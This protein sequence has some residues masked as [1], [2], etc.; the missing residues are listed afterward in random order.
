[1]RA[2]SKSHLKGNYIETIIKESKTN[3]KGGGTNGKGKEESDYY[4]QKGPSSSYSRS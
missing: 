4:N 2:P 1:M 3:K